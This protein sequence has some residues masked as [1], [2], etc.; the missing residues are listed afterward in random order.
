[1]KT[2]KISSS[3]SSSPKKDYSEIKNSLLNYSRKSGIAL[4]T[5]TV[6]GLGVYPVSEKP[7]N[8]GTPILISFVFKALK[9]EKGRKY[10]PKFSPENYE[11]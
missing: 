11:K 9:G 6:N 8:K 1:M 7:D 4:R 2:T 10:P 5:D 3:S